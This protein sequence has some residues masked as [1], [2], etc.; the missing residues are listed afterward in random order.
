MHMTS[1]LSLLVS[2]LTLVACT[3]SSTSEQGSDNPPSDSTTADAAQGGEDTASITPE[4][5]NAGVII[6]EIVASPEGD[7]ADW[8]EL[9]AAGTE[10]VDL[11]AFTLVDDNPDHAPASLPEV[12]LQPGEY[13]VILA[14]DADAEVFAPSV[15][16]K[17]GSD[18]GVWL[19]REGQ[20]VDSLDWDEDAAPTGSSWGRLPNGTTTLARLTPTPGAANVAWDGTEPEPEPED[21]DLFP[22]DRV[23]TIAITM[24]ES[25]W[26]SVLQ[27][28][29][30]E[31][32]QEATLTID[33]MVAEN[34]AVRTKGNS[35]LNS[36]A[37]NA[38]SNRYS[39]KVDTNRY[40]D[41]QKLCGLKKFNLNNG[42]K[43][44]SLIR[45]HIGYQLARAIGLPAPRTS[46]ADVT[47]NGQ[48]LGLYTLVEHVDSEFI[49]RWFDDDTGDLYKPDWPDGTLEWKGDQLA[50]YEGI[51]IESNEET[52]DHSAFM[53]L[54]K[55]INGQSDAALSTVLDTDM[56]LRY[57]A[58]NT[59]LVNLDS[60]SG[61]G[62]NYYVYEVDG[63]FTPIPWDLNEAFGNFTC[64]C[65]REGIITLMIDEPTCGARA[66][67]PMVEAVLKDAAHVAQYHAYLGE[68][69]AEGGPFSETVMAEAIAATADL[70]RPYVEADTEKFFSTAQFETALNDDVTSGGGPGGGNAIG[71]T[72]FVSERTAA[73]SDQLEGATP[74]GAGG[75]G[76][77][78][79]GPGGGGQNPK[80]PDG[81]CDGFEQANPEVCPEDCQ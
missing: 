4:V 57:L 11:S 58:L 36:V 67:K 8:I 48:H 2:L 14:V 73:I 61:N 22:D 45:E 28:P 62:H 59:M 72:T 65:N 60:Y 15:P 80:C 19:A 70:I 32:Y 55:V 49:E 20:V 74:S 10:A 12:T 54:L 35:S 81:I 3:T 38:N 51:D 17:L 52:T 41:G 6:N 69:I 25:A 79:G 40:V 66:E 29:T 77:C 44:P 78:G 9:Y 53:Q 5:T 71:L 1:R 26:Q 18:D 43:D 23:L 56:M 46:F 76:S 34:M 24:E 7:E 21:C 64:G 39:W 27:D 33:G 16:F 75:A 63:V 13:F 37:N 47:I 31:A 68:F 42:F 30:A 50:D